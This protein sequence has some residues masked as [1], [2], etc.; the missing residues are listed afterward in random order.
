MESGR[1]SVWLFEL[2]ETA[3]RKHGSSGEKLL[4]TFSQ[5]GYS[6]LY[7]DEEQRRLGTKGDEGDSDRE[8]YVSCRDVEALQTRLNSGLNG[9]VKCS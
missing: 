2:N 5:H 1:I 8:N 4:E 9:E 3:L 7:W 6:I